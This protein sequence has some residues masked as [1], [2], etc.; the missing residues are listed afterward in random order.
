M[1]DIKTIVCAKQVP[2]PEAPASAVEGDSER[3]LVTVKGLPPEINPLDETALEAALQL[4][5]AYGGKITVVSVG[6][7]L[8]EH[9]LCKTLAA[10]ADELILVNDEGLDELDSYSAALVLYKAIEKICKY[11]LILTGRQAGDWDSG[12]TGLILSEFLKIPA[13]NWVKKIKIVDGEAHV[14]KLAPR[15]CE[16]VI[17]PLPL[18]LTISSEF[19]KMRYVSLTAFKEAREKAI[20]VWRME[21]LG[22]DSSMLRKRKVVT[23][24]KPYMKRDCLFVEGKTSEDIG[25]NLAVKL[26]EI[27]RS[28]NIAGT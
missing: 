24:F 19:G 20:N 6:A 23:L 3:L 16:I 18:L 25:K 17:A 21:D 22:V 14:A 12:Q 1:K 26:K 5:E 15:G 13:I 11:D 4:K 28:M 9:V 27:L 10:G 7:N 8:S 2:N